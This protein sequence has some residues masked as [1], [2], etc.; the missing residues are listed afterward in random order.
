MKLIYISRLSLIAAVIMVSAS[1]R[2]QMVGGNAFLQGQYVEVGVTQY[3][4]Y[5]TSSSPTTYHSHAPGTVG[6]PLVSCHA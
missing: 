5:G 3:G 6:G 1:A 2:G 4:S